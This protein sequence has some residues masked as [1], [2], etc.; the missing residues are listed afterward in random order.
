MDIDGVV[1]QGPRLIPGSADAIQRLHEAGV[2]VIFVTNGGGVTEAAKAQELAALL[3]N[4]SIGERHVLLSHTPMR[5]LADR[6]R[7]RRVLLV[8]AKESTAVAESYG[9]DV[10]GGMAVTSAQLVAGTRGLWTMSRPDPGQLPPVDINGEGPPIEA[11]LLLFDPKDWAVDLQVLIDVLAG[12][13]PVGT[14]TNSGVLQ[15]AVEVYASNPDFVWQA[16]YAAPRFGQ[17]A[18]IE[19][20]AALWR[21]RSGGSQLKVTEFGKPHRVQFQAAE[22]MLA[23]VAAATLSGKA[24]AGGVPPRRI[25]MVGDNPAA[26]IRGANAA[27]DRWRSILVCTGVYKGGAESNDPLDPAWRV[28]ENLGSAVERLLRMSSAEHLDP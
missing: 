25:Y 4:T 19:C 6:Y 21:R 8:G 9:F 22:R 18:F 5:E 2:P 11:A 3:G 26:D 16:E 27:G 7:G 28:E 14:G 1:R 15:Q 12:G 10:R 13:K 20:L 24:A 17:G 23:H